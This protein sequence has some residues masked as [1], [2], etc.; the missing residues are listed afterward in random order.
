[1]FFF[2]ASLAIV[3]DLLNFL[4][5]LES[6]SLLLDMIPLNMYIGFWI[7]FYCI[8]VNTLPPGRSKIAEWL[9]SLRRKPAYQTPE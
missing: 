6:K 1:M 5:Y 8:A 3:I 4:L 9:E 2:L 7:F